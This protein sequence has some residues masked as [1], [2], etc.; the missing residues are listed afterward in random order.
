[1]GADTVLLISNGCSVMLRSAI[2]FDVLISSYSRRNARYQRIVSAPRILAFRNLYADSRGPSDIRDLGFNNATAMRNTE[3]FRRSNFSVYNCNP[4]PAH[5]GSWVAHQQEFYPTR[6]RLRSMLTWF[7]LPNSW[8]KTTTR[9][10]PV[11]A[12]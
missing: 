1:M 9:S 5:V 6:S 12:R 3:A 2:C 10:G 11:W 8:S 4:R 7:S